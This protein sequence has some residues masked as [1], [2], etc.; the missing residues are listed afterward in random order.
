MVSLEL[1]ARLDN[2]LS[3]AQTE[4]ADIDLFAP[5]I[6]REECPICLIPL[7]NS[8]EVI[9]KSCCGKVI[10][11]GCFTKHWLTEMKK[12]NHPD[13]H[14]CAFCQSPSLI[15]QKRIKSLKKLM[16]KN[17][18]NAFIEMVRYYK[19]GDGVMQ[20]DTR[21]LEMFIKAAEFGWADAYGFIAN[22]HV[23][24]AG[25]EQDESKSLSLYELSAKKGDKVIAYKDESPVD[26]IL[27]IEIFPV[28][29]VQSQEEIY[30]SLEDI[31]DDS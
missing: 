30:V 7:P 2:L 15:G 27:G 18:P 13:E 9:Y 21:A 31:K 25:V 8:N 16:K 17:D 10:C 26:T 4:T 6:E 24:G 22:H 29:H 23:E 28:V 20:S 11:K 5:I 12:G 19:S 14:K 3:T 1:E